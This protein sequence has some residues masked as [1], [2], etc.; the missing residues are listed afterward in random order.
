M[1]IRTTQ[2]EGNGDFRSTEAIELLKEADIVVTNPPFSLFREYIAQLIQYDKKFLVVGNYNSVTYK[3]IFPLFKNNKMWIGVSPR[4]MDFILPDKSIVKVNACW[5]TNLP[6]NK[7]SQKIILYKNYTPKDYS[8][9]DNLDA[10][11]VDKVKDIPCDYDGLIG[12]PITFLEKHN[13]DQFEIIALGV[14]LDNFTPNKEYLNPKKHMTNGKVVGGGAMNYQLAIEA[15]SRP[16]GTY[17]TSD[18]SAYLTA[19]Y[20]RILIKKK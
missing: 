8:K 6:H 11:N 10:I 1:K 4:S 3:E 14:G 17:Y 5:F 15:S 18:N 7:R 19:P 13:P 12:G 20:A 9:Y 16:T 2:L